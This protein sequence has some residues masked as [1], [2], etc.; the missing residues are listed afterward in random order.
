MN[1]ALSKLGW[2]LLS[3]AGAFCLGVVALKRGEQIDALWLLAAAICVYLVAYRFYGLFVANKVLQVDPTRITPA[4]KHNDGLDYVPTDR[5]TLYGAHFSAIAGAGPLV[6]PV[7]A[8][9]MG[10]LPG[11]LWILAGAVFAGAVQDMMALYT[12]VRRDAKSLGDMIK[13]EMGS[14]TGLIISIGIFAIL[15]IIIA[16]LALIV[17]KALANSP[18]GLFTV[19]MT[20]PTAFFMGIY[21]RY[22]RPGR[23]GEVSIIGFALLMASII[24]GQEVAVH[25]HPLRSF[26]DFDADTLAIML[27]IYGF[28]AA[29]IPVWLLMAPRGLL[30]TFLK[31]GVI[32]LLAVGILF[33]NPSFDMPAV[34]QFIDG[35]GPVFAGELFPFLFITIACGAISGFHAT[36]SSGTTSKMLSSEGDLCL[37]GYGGMLMESFVAIMALITATI[38][39]PGVFFAM[40]SGENLYASPQQMEA[41]ATQPD[42][43]E[44]VKIAAENPTIA[45]EN[46]EKMAIMAKAASMYTENLVPPSADGKVYT[47]LDPKELLTWAKNV[48]EPSIM[49]RTGGAPTLA[50][51]ISYI[52]AQMT[53]GFSS[54]DGDHSALMS[55]WYHFA[56]VFEALFILTTVDAGTRTG[57]YMV[58]DLVGMIIPPMKRTDSKVAMIIATLICVG[59]WGYFL[60]NGVVD[61]NGGVRTLWPLFGISNQMLAGIALM[62]CSV[63]LFKMKRDKYAWVPL[64]PG[65]FVTLCTV[66]AGFEKILPNMPA[67]L[68]FVAKYLQLADQAK[69]TTDPEVLNTIALEQT[70]QV[71]DAILTGVFLVLVFVM[72]FATIRSIMV[73][74]RNPNPTAI[75]WDYGHMDPNAQKA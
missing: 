41:A 35:T 67:H 1:S 3:I 61:P 63:V 40:N 44:L 24:Y 4:V 53:A 12:S 27:I 31:I 22:I 74:R 57:R 18:W 50:V 55:F 17:V 9:Q 5:W 28:F 10:Y 34:T 43:P 58:H 51:G 23:V 59:I 25:G 13:L 36:V 73:A 7:L 49:S 38:I 71:V 46:A 21:T 69:T 15:M 48:G 39:H 65:I 30:S 14:G 2:L 70:I 11:T 16:A 54:G 20:I 8:A 75:V 56:I 72:I 32:A 33:V 42:I 66:V 47:H 60:W 45:P 6:G 29:I 37:I 52:L 64:I 26:F 68:S 62:F 19:A